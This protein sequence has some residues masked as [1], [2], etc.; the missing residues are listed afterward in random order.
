MG[1]GKVIV[2]CTFIAFGGFLFGYDIG[3]IRFGDLTN[4]VYVLDS[5]RQ[6]EITAL[7]SAGT[8]VGALAQAFTADTFGRKGSILI[9]SVIFTMLVTVTGLLLLRKA[10]ACLVGI[11]GVT[12]QTA[13]N[14]SL[15][16]LLFGRFA[17]GL[18]VG[19]LSAL[20]PMFNGEAAPKHLRGTLLVMY[21]V[22]SQYAKQVLLSLTP[23]CHPLQLMIIFGIFVPEARLTPPSLQIPVGLQML[24][25]LILVV[26]ICAPL[27]SSLTG[28]CHLFSFYNS[29]AVLPESPRHLIFKDKI[30]EA[31]LAI[32][33]MNNTDPE[34]ELTNEIMAELV[35][36]LQAENEGGKATWL[37]CFSPEVRMRTVSPL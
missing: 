22:D 9:W 35:E 19:A 13:T 32:A 3:V 29:E 26:G 5:V 1:Q 8:F 27:N 18:G 24:W 12:I 36:G 20:V 2:I 34:S 16:Q 17:A 37:E 10:N 11:S 28:R 21:Q 23:N 14:T 7:L 6:S 25:G 33:A 31:R 4:G 15:G 30:Q